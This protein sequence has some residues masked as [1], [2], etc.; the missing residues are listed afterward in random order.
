MKYRIKTGLLAALCLLAA[1]LGAFY[2]SLP[3]LA[4]EGASLLRLTLA[5]QPEE[6]V[7][8]G[9]V[10]LSLTI[11]NISDRDAQNV[12][13]SSSDGLLSEPVGQ[14]AAGQSQTIRRTHSVTQAELDAGAITYTVSHDDPDEAGRKVNYSVQASIH[15]ND[16]HPEAEFT[17]QFSSRYV[18]PGDTVTITYR[19]RN[20][21]NVAL[22]AL[23]VQDELGDFTGR[24]DRL[25]AGE[26]RMLI[27][28]V[29]LTEADSSAATLTY[30]VEALEGQ[31]FVTTLS[32]A[33][34]RMAYARMEAEL[35]ASY[36]AFSTNTAN[37]VLL[38]TNLGN[39]DYTNIRVIDDIYG[40]VIADNV[41]VPSGVADPVELSCSY[42]VRG[43]AGFR[44]RI[45]GISETGESIEL[46]TDTVT[47]EPREITFPA[48][49]TMRVEALTP[50][51]R[52][53]G[54]V[55]MRLRIENAGDADVTD[56]VLS[57]A[58]LGEIE[59]YAVIPAGGS[60]EREF[61]LH[62][63]QETQFGFSILYTDI[64]GWQRSLA[65]APVEVEIASDGVL[66]EDAKQPFIEFTG[67]SIKVVGSSLYATLLIVG[68]GVLLVLIVILLI[69]SRRAR[70]EKQLRIAAEK[71]RRR[72][73]SARTGA[74]AKKAAARERGRDGKDNK[75][76]KDVR[77][78]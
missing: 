13:L 41:T 74:P 64:T 10:T 42:P 46:V 34:V 5:A 8:P 3:A 52:R 17:R 47:L 50:K 55:T 30:D 24:V 66:P 75:D 44:W 78:R 53:A 9:D 36:S 59:R 49:I 6:L 26:S 28:R 25:E 2:G 60:I 77:E 32:E 63:A 4:E 48:E 7:E 29:T 57:E 67:N 56:I 1:L 14:I 11:E 73:G 70:L 33:P 51:I 31:S 15:K 21:G 58:A 35:S 16:L 20:S 23:R 71:Q 27:S 54:E 65:C 38:L 68:C 72:E 69:V 39:V 61:G 76:G 45:T 19:I 40:G 22:T 43:D 62:V 37:V 12:Y 18:A